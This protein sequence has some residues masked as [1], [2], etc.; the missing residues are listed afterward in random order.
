MKSLK[1]LML[2]LLCSFFIMDLFAQDSETCYGIGVNFAKDFVYANVGEDFS[3]V[4]LP[5]DFS[6]FS[7]IIRGEK[8]RVE[9]SCGYFRLSSSYSGPSSSSEYTSS[10]WRLGLSLASNST[11]GSMHHYY[12]ISV[13]FIFSSISGEYSSEF[14]SDKE[15]D[16]K[17]DFF[18]GPVL[19]GEYNFSEYLSLGGEV[20]I[21]YI[22]LGQYDHDSD[23]DISVWAITTRAIIVLRWYFK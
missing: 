6:N 18:I 9:P 21:N 16:S 12:G 14:F 23:E 1:F 17:T 7:V 2:L 11:T 20:Q 19:G 3:I 4:S 22:S 13:G 5:Y 10:N 15:D 8:Y